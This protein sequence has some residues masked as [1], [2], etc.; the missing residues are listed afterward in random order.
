MPGVV[1]GED[2]CRN[3]D[4]TVIGAEF[5]ECPMIDDDEWGFKITGGTQFGM[6]IT[7]FYVNFD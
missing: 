3:G 5:G 2:D 1:T 7:I 6:P 4:T